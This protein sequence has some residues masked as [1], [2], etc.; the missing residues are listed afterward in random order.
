ML[1]FIMIMIPQL[2]VMVVP[3]VEENELTEAKGAFHVKTKD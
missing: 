3:E 2:L 1:G